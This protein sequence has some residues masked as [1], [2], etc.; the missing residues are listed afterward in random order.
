MNEPNFILVP[1]DSKFLLW[2]RIDKRDKTL[3]ARLA[4]C[5]AGFKEARRTWKEELLL[6]CDHAGCIAR[7]I[8]SWAEREKELTFLFLAYER[9]Q[10]SFALLELETGI[11]SLSS[12]I[13]AAIKTELILQIREQL[14]DVR[15]Q[16]ASVKDIAK[17]VMSRLKIPED[18]IKIAVQTILPTIAES[19]NRLTLEDS[20]LELLAS[21]ASRARYQN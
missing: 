11:A 19:G 2:G 20:Q 7:R 17:A 15:G 16:F 13:E 8:D 9:S 21:L 1:I 10:H 6:S 12:F 3:S 4:S 5:I 18:G 14:K